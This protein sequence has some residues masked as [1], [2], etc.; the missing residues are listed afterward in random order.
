M[1]ADLLLEIG[2]EEIPSRYMNQAL[3]DL[4]SLALNMLRENR[5]THGE[6]NTMGTP[7][8]L[9]LVIPGL[10]GRQT[11]AFTKKRGPRLSAAYDENGQPTKALLGFA[12][13]Q[14]LDYSQL[15]T[16]E[17]DGVKYVAAVKREEGQATTEILPRLLESIIKAMSFPRS[18][19]WG[20]YQT[21]FARPIRWLLCLLGDEVI[22]VR[23]ENLTS[24]RYTYGHRFLSRGALE[25]RNPQ[26]YLGQ[27]RDSFVI[28]DQDERRKMIWQQI[29]EVAR[30]K[31]GKPME[32]EAL[33]DEVNF[34]V[35]YPTAF[36]GTFSSDYLE[37]PSEVLTTSMIEHQRYFPVFDDKGRLLPGFIGVR[38]GT[39]FAIDT[40]VA[41][42]QR[43]LKARLEDALFFWREDSKKPLHEYVPGLAQVMFHERLGS[44]LDKVK[45]LQT[46]AVFLGE[47]AN[48]GS[49]E[50]IKQAARL[51][52]A[53]L[54]SGMVYEFPELQGIMGR[55]YALLSGEDEEVA[56]AIFEHYLPR[57]A[58][59]GLPCSQ[60]G[61]AISLAEKVDNLVGFFALN[62]KPTGSQDPYALRRQAI[63]LINIILDKGLKLDLEGL[64]KEAYKGFAPF[65]LENEQDKTTAELMDFIRGRMRG[66]LLEKGYS[67]D[68]IDAVL[69]NPLTTA[70]VHA[71]EDLVRAIQEARGRQLLTDFM[72]VFTRAHNLSRQ[73]EPGLPVD[74][75]LLLDDSEKALFSQ[76]KLISASFSGAVADQQYHLAL[77]LISSLRPNLDRF[78][79]AVMVMV[80]DEGLRRARLGLLRSIADMCWQMADFTKIVQ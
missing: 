74:E 28:L 78:F 23:I 40:V 63:G 30:E 80:E 31:G 56:Q 13:G 51:A 10:A 61:L 24:S 67:Y 25:I 9:V 59:D 6:I 16:V 75:K 76:L 64:F 27:L 41:G 72:V 50:K 54:L 19:R 57:F 15:D 29:V 35:E 22:P 20:Y 66:V 68:I 47:Q 52:K 1:S 38:N 8:R 17:A 69:L 73:V 34:L 3:T 46:L 37:V 26:D 4:R 5:L 21:R 55:Y 71:L 44:L 62:I 77:S 42:N 43:V 32:N 79:E 48:L 7:R 18:M 33:L 60:T 70:D 58:G 53:D 14:G 36:W 2:V 12:R 49:T 39:D 45:R 11:D 65:E